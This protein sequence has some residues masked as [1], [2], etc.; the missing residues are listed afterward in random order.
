MPSNQSRTIHET[1]FTDSSSTGVEITAGW[2][3]ED[4][5]VMNLNELKAMFPF[6]NA[7]ELISSCAMDGNR[8][9]WIG[10]AARTAQNNDS[11]NNFANL[12]P[13][14]DNG[15]SENE[16]GLIHCHS[17]SVRS[18]PEMVSAVKHLSVIR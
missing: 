17:A 11:A 1:R 5:I 3:H 7:H 16:T 9:R 8:D 12:R 14:T 18:W 6:A 15:Y 10:Q 13:V 4:G 2:T